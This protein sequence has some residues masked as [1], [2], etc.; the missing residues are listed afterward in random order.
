M[1]RADG[2]ADGEIRKIRF[3]RRFTR[4]PA[5]SCLVEA[6]KTVVL[7]TVSVVPGVPEWM[8][9]RGGGW[10]TA[11]YSMLPG[12]TPDRKPRDSTRGKIDGRT[13]EIQRLVG[14]SLRAAVNL[15]DLRENTLWVDCDVLQADGG[16]R[17][18]AV[19]GAYL[20]LVDALAW[21]EER[22]MLSGRPSVTPVGAISVGIVGGKVLADLD[23]S[24]DVK[25]A[26][27]MNVV[28]AGEDRFVELQ[29]TGEHTAFSGEDLS[30][31][32]AAA[33]E[34]IRQVRAWQEAALKE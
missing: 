23:Y 30:V 19:N 2:R 31:M 22:R 25:A 8:K 18:V 11:E 32:V 13:Q 26:V 14:R 17:T 24:E 33:R 1:P 27:D 21:M 6:G 15:K 5:G 3:T 7:C 34:G 12:S 4:V 20:A 9:G 29:G 28:M 10:L 16:T